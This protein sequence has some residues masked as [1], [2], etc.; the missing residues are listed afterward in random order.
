MDGK[1]PETIMALRERNKTMEIGD[2]MKY[3]AAD[4]FEKLRD[5]LENRNPAGTTMTKEL[6][7][8]HLYRKADNKIRSNVVAIVPI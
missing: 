6:V 3:K 4:Y 5:S 8:P 1:T 7:A 2:T